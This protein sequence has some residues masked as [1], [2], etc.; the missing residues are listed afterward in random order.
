METPASP[1]YWQRQSGEEPADFTAFVAYLKLKGRRSHRAVA[2]QTGRP[3]GAI[4][5]LSARHNWVGR[6]AA[7]ETRLAD[8]SQDALD[9]MVRAATSRTAADFERLR[10]SAFLLARRVLEESDRWLKLA[11][12]PRRRDVS[13]G[14]ICRLLELATTL[15]RRAAG[16]PLGDEPSRPPVREDASGYMTG[17]EA[18]KKIYGAPANAPSVSPEAGAA[19]SLPPDISVSPGP[20]I[21]PETTAGIPPQAVS[22]NPEPVNASAPPLAA[23]ATEV[24]PAKFGRRDAWASWSRIQGGRGR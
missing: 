5:R 10:I 8:A 16:M 3:L 9:V 11:C 7:F 6:V 13:L 4:R 15:G 2:T 19:G 22:S 12:D 17:E 20:D 14:Q 1:R 24:A 23:E 21:S 18:L